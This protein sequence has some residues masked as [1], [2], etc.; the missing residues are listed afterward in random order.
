MIVPA[1][2]HVIGSERKKERKKESKPSHQGL[3]AGTLQLRAG[4]KRAFSLGMLYD[5]QAKGLASHLGLAS[6]PPEVYSQQVSDT[7]DQAE[8]FEC[9]G[10]GAQISSSTGLRQNHGHPTRD[11]RG[12]R[13]LQG[14]ARPHWLL[15]ICRH[16]IRVSQQDGAHH[17]LCCCASWACS[18]RSGH[19][20]YVSSAMLE[21]EYEI[22]R[23]CPHL[24]PVSQQ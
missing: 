17:L 21:P 15:C 12:L 18:A 7:Q 22:R 20:K 9:S 23:W 11:Q 2:G 19:S 10:L 3:L 16:H 1:C 14:C 24:S 13:T 8:P 5:L 6:Q 4:T